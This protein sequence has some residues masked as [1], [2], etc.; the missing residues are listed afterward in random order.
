MLQTVVPMGTQ[1]VGLDVH[2]YGLVDVLSPRFHT[3]MYYIQQVKNK[4]K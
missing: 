1:P 3:I 2:V 4:I